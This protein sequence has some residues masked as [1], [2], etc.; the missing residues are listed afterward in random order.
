MAEDAVDVAVRARALTATG[1]S[2]ASLRLVDRI[3][4]PAEGL[5]DDRTGLSRA[6][7]EYAV[8]V[9]GAMTAADVLD[10]RT[11]V[12]LVDADRERCRPAVEELV[13]RTLSDLF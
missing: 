13:E 6:E 4:P 2:T 7:V 5:I 10:R 9:E 8:R 3:L 1:S 11:R 12:G